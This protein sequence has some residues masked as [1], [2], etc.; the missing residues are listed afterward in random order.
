[1]NLLLYNR[2]KPLVAATFY[3]HLQRGINFFEGYITK[4]T[5]LVV[6][7]YIFRK[8]RKKQ[9]VPKDGHKR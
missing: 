3:D 6:L 5:S 4:I 2:C 9:H 8:K 1:M 7:K